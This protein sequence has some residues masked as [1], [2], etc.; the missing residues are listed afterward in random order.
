MFYKE[1]K[2]KEKLNY[3]NRNT[4][5]FHKKIREKH[6]IEISLTLALNKTF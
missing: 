4:E 6:F 3:T 2:L 5:L 1:K